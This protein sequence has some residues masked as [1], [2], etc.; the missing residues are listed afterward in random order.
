MATLSEASRTSKDT[1]LLDRFEAAAAAAGVANPR[2]WVSERARHLASAP[3]SDAPGS[4]SIAD[5]YTFAFNRQ[6][7]FLASTVLALWSGEVMQPPGA[8]Q[9]AVTD[10]YIDHA[11]RHVMAQEPA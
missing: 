9:G 6:R 4:Q 10:G 3:I 7:E 8:N 11:V 2:V 1:D 5:V